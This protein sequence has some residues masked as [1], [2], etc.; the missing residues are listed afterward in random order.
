[1]PTIAKKTE[2]HR[3][4]IANVLRSIAAAPDVC[5]LIIDNFDRA[6]KVSRDEGYG[7]CAE[8]VLTVATSLNSYGKA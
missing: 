4:A 1:M 7:H 6:C 3:R 2:D 5:E 8:Q